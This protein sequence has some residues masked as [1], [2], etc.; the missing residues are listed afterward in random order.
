M[1]FFLT[2]MQEDKCGKAICVENTDTN[3]PLL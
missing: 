1:Y 2:F 3:P